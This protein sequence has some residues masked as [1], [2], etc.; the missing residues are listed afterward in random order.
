MTVPP[1]P[2]GQSVATFAG[3]CFWSMQKAFDGIFE[4]GYVAVVRKKPGERAKTRLFFFNHF[5]D[6]PRACNGLR[7]TW[8]RSTGTIKISVPRAC[9]PG[10]RTR[11]VYVAARTI[12][13]DAYDDAP[14][15]V[16]L[17]RG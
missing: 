16:R 11:R 12:R 9:L 7:G 2:A 3:G 8:T 10:H 6:S 4:A 17:R 13:G 14:A 5:E 1:A 15:V